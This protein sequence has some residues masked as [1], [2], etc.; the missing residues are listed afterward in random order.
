MKNRLGVLKKLDNLWKLVL[1][2]ILMVGVYCV[3]CYPLYRASK[4][5]ILN[6]LYEDLHDMDLVEISEDDEEIL[7]DYQKEKFETVIVDGLYIPFLIKVRTY[8]KI[9]TE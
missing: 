8:T 3:C 5:R 9:Y 7:A 1:I 2:F 4:V 6:Q